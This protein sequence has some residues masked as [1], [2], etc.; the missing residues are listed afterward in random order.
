MTIHR[1]RNFR[2][3]SE[4]DWDERWYDA[5]YR[6]D[7]LQRV[8]FI[9]E[10]FGPS[11][12]A[13]H[14]MVSFEFGGDRFVALSVE[15]R[16]ERGESFSPLRG[17]LRNYEL[18]YVWGDERD[19][20]ELRTNFRHD[21]LWLHPSDVSQQAAQRYLLSLLRRTN[22]LREQPAFY[23]TALSSCST[24]LADHLQAVSP[25]HL[26][27]DWRTRIPGYTDELAWELGLLA[28]DGPWQELRERHEISARALAAGDSDDFS[29]RIREGI[30]R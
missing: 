17:V 21:P 24:N 30:E 3:R 29:V 1:V 12:A 19:L 14:A 9:V 26:A 16:K 15:I 4:D 11:R 22:E 20:I 23:N 28:G 5:T 8:W 18:M 10:K 25:E 13:A 7:E 2:Y 27:L 6:L